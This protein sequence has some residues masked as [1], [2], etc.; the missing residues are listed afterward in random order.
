[1]GR[2]EVPSTGHGTQPQFIDRPLSYQTSAGSSTDAGNCHDF[3]LL[4]YCS[5][6]MTLCNEYSE[7]LPPLSSWFDMM[8]RQ[9]VGDTV[10]GM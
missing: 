5:G 1:M 6:V 10:F 4:L 8:M 2:R 3:Q 9:H 7:T